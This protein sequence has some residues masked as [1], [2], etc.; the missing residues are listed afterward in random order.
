MISEA[1]RKI[2]ENLQALMA[3]VSADVEEI[4]GQPMAITMIVFNAE[5]GSRLNYISTCDRVQAIE[6][7]KALLKGWGEGMPDIPAHEVN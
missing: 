3:K 7:Y 5:P 4:A 6:V 2:S 1:D